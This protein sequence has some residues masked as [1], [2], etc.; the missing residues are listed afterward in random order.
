MKFIRLYAAVI[1]AA[2]SISPSIQ[3]ADSH[4]HLGI[5]DGHRDVGHTPKKGRSSYDTTKDEYLVTGSGANI[6]LNEDAFQYLFKKIEGDVSL[7][8]DT[9]FQYPIM[10]HHSKAA[11]M[12]RQSLDANAAYADIVLHADELI[13][14]QYRQNAGETT[15][16]LRPTQKGAMR[17]RITRHGDQ[18]SVALGDPD[19]P[20]SSLGPVT[21]AMQGPVYVGLAV[22]SHVANALQ[23]VSF[24]NVKLDEPGK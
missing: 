10:Q 9:T 2:C 3:A 20:L 21:V 1:L 5:F 19:K 23:T 7:T 18:F 16:E 8:A 4:G 17:I 15:Q 13:T 12:I 24:S 22:C 14:L 11:L 6:W